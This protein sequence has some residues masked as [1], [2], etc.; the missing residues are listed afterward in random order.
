[1]IRSIDDRFFA[2][3]DRLSLATYVKNVKDEL[4]DDLTR[5]HEDLKSAAYLDPDKEDYHD[6]L[7][8]II[9]R[10]LDLRKNHE[11]V[12]GTINDSTA[13]DVAAETIAELKDKNK[14]RLAEEINAVTPENV[15]SVEVAKMRGTGVEIERRT[16]PP[17][18]EIKP[19]LQNV[20]VIQKVGLDK[21]MKGNPVMLVSTL[22]G[23]QR[24]LS[25][26]VETN[27]QRLLINAG[28]AVEEMLGYTAFTH[29]PTSYLTEESLNGEIAERDI[30]LD[31]KREEYGA[32]GTTSAKKEVLAKEIKQLSDEQMEIR[33][34]LTAVKR[35]LESVTDILVTNV[36][37]S[38]TEHLARI[39]GF[40]PRV[41]VYA[42]KEA[43]VSSMDTVRARKSG[44][45][46]S[47]QEFLRSGGRF[48]HIEDGVTINSMKSELE[49]LKIH[50]VEV[51]R[52]TF[53]TVVENVETG[54][55]IA[56]IPLVDRGKED[57][58]RKLLTGFGELNAIY[59]QSPATTVQLAANGDTK[60]IGYY[61]TKLLADDMGK[62]ISEVY[63]QPDNNIA[64][65]L[66]YVE[67]VGADDNL[68]AGTQASILSK[69]LN[70]GATE[71]VRVGIASPLRGQ[72]NSIFV[73][74]GRNMMVSR[75]M[76]IS[77]A[78]ADRLSNQAANI[79]SKNRIIDVA[80]A[81][82][83][84]DMKAAVEATNVE[85]TA[86]GLMQF[87]E[88]E[89]IED[90][91]LSGLGAQFPGLNID[92]DVPA[93]AY[94]RDQWIADNVRR[95]VKEGKFF[96]DKDGVVR[97]LKPPP[98]QEWDGIKA[99]FKF[100]PMSGTSGMGPEY[101]WR[102]ILMQ[103]KSFGRKI[104]EKEKLINILVDRDNP[105]E[106]QKAFDIL[107]NAQ[108]I[109]VPQGSRG[110]TIS[111]IAARFELVRLYN[112]AIAIRGDAEIAIARG[113]DN[114][115]STYKLVDPERIKNIYSAY[116]HTLLE[117]YDNA[118]I[119][120][121]GEFTP[122]NSKANLDAIKARAEY[123][124]NLMKQFGDRNFAS[125]QVLSR[126]RVNI[127]SNVDILLKTND[128]VSFMD[129]A[130]SRGFAKYDAKA[131]WGELKAATAKIL[132]ENDIRNEL[133]D[134]N[135]RLHDSYYSHN[136]PKKFKKGA[137]P[138]VLVALNTMKYIMRNTLVNDEGRLL[139]RLKGTVELYS[140][141]VDQ[142]QVIVSG[143]RL[144][145]QIQET[146]RNLLK[147]KAL[148]AE[149][150]AHMSA[151]KAFGKE[152]NMYVH[153][154]E[155]VI[156]SL[157]GTNFV[158]F[159]APEVFSDFGTEKAGLVMAVKNDLQGLLSNENLRGAKRVINPKFK[160]IMA[161]IEE[162]DGRVGA[163]K[164]S[165]V[166]MAQGLRGV[167]ETHVN[168][169]MRIFAHEM[170]R[171]KDSPAEY[172]KVFDKAVAFVN[173][174]LG[175][176]PKE[177]QPDII[178]SLPKIDQLRDITK[179]VEPAVRDHV[180][181]A[182]DVV[183]SRFNKIS[184]YAPVV[185]SST[186]TYMVRN[187]VREAFSRELVE[188]ANRRETKLYQLD[189]IMQ[190]LQ[191]I[192]G[193]IWGIQRRAVTPGSGAGTHAA[194]EILSL[195]YDELH[196]DARM[197]Q[198]A[199]AKDSMLEGL[200]DAGKEIESIGY[201]WAKIISTNPVRYAGSIEAV[202]N[203]NK[204]QHVP[205]YLTRDMDILHTDMG[206][207][208]L[209]KARIL[210][211]HNQVQEIMKNIQDGG[212]ITRDSYIKVTDAL[213][214]AVPFDD[215]KLFS[216]LILPKVERYMFVNEPTIRRQQMTAHAQQIYNAFQYR[217]T[218][219]STRID[220]A[221]GAIDRV[222]SY[223]TTTTKFPT[224]SIERERFAH[225]IDRVKVKSF[226]LAINSKSDV[227]RYLLPDG[228]SQGF[229][230]HG[231][232]M[233][234]D[235]VRKYGFGYTKNDTQSAFMFP[236]RDTAKDIAYKVNLS[237][238]M[239][240]DQAEKVLAEAE[241]L[242][243][244]LGVK[245]VVVEVPTSVFTGVGFDK[246]RYPL[247]SERLSRIK[248]DATETPRGIEGAGGQFGVL[249]EDGRSVLRQ[250]PTVIT[251]WD[252][253]SSEVNKGV[254]KA[255]EDMVRPPSVMSDGLIHDVYD[256][257]GVAVSQAGTE[258][259]YAEYVAESAK[260]RREADIEKISKSFA[261]TFRKQG[262][263]LD[264]VMR[265]GDE[266][267]YASR[268][269][270]STSGVT[271]LTT[272][273]VPML[274]Y[275]ENGNIRISR[276]QSDAQTQL[277]L[278]QGAS[279]LPTG[280]QFSIIIDQAADGAYVVKNKAGVLPDYLSNE[281]IYH[282][283]SSVVNAMTNGAQEA[284][285]TQAM[286]EEAGE[287]AALAKILSIPITT[288][289]DTTH[290]LSGAPLTRKEVISTD[291]IKQI[292]RE[293]NA[294]LIAHTAA[295][296]HAS[297]LQ[298]SRREA[299]E[300]VSIKKY[301]ND[302]K[303]LYTR[304]IDQDYK[305]AQLARIKNKYLGVAGVD[306]F[307]VGAP[308][309][310]G[311]IVMANKK[312][313]AGGVTIR[314]EDMPKP[315]FS[316][317][318][319]DAEIEFL[320]SQRVL[321]PED[322]HAIQERIAT[323]R[324]YRPI[325]MSKDREI[326]IMPGAM[327]TFNKMLH[328]NLLQRAVNLSKTI[329]PGDNAEQKLVLERL[330][331]LANEAREGMVDG[332]R[333][334]SMQRFLSGAMRDQA[335]MSG[336][337]PQLIEE[338]NELLN[339]KRLNASQRETLQGLETTIK[340]YNEKMELRGWAV[341]QLGVI[342]SMDVEDYNTVGGYNVVRKVSK[343]AAQEL[344]KPYLEPV[345][346]HIPPAR[347][348][349][350][351][352]MGVNRDY[353]GLF[354][355]LEDLRER[356]R[357]LEDKRSLVMAQRMQRLGGYIKK[358]IE[359]YTNHERYYTDVIN[360]FEKLF[361]DG[362]VKR[363]DDP[364][365]NAGI[366]KQHLRNVQPFRQD[367]IPEVEE[368]FKDAIKVLRKEKD[369][370]AVVE[371]KDLLKNLEGINSKNV[372]LRSDEYHINEAQE[373]ID[374]ARMYLGRLNKARTESESA[375]SVVK[376]QTM[377]EQLS[378]QLV[379][380]YDR[381]GVLDSRVETL[382]N[383]VKSTYGKYAV[384]GL[385]P[386]AK[387]KN[388][389]NELESQQ[390]V[391][392]DPLKS[393]DEVAVANKAIGALEEE[394]ANVKEFMRTHNKDVKVLHKQIEQHEIDFGSRNRLSVPYLTQQA[395][396][397]RIKAHNL[398]VEVEAQ[399]AA[400]VPVSKEHVNLISKYESTS[401]MFQDSMKSKQ[402]LYHQLDALY[403]EEQATRVEMLKLTTIRPEYREIGTWAE[404]YREIAGKLS[405]QGDGIKQ[406][407]NVLA[408]N[409]K[410]WF[411][412]SLF[413]DVEDVHKMLGKAINM[414][415]GNSEPYIH[416]IRQRRIDLGL[417]RAVNK[418]AQNRVAVIMGLMDGYF[419]SQNGLAFGQ[420]PGAEDK[421]IFKGIK[422]R[423]EWDAIIAGIMVPASKT[424]ITTIKLPDGT[425]KQVA[426]GTSNVEMIKALSNFG[427]F[428]VDMLD[429]DMVKEVFGEM[430]R[431]KLGK[432]R[433]TQ[434]ITG[435]LVKIEK[436]FEP[437]RKRLEDPRVAELADVYRGALR[438]SLMRHLQKEEKGI[439][440][441]STVEADTLVDRA[442]DM[443]MGY[444]E[445]FNEM[446]LG[447]A[448]L[449]RILDRSFDKETATRQF[450]AARGQEYELGRQ[451]TA[452]KKEIGDINIEI[453]GSMEPGAKRTVVR[454]LEDRLID[455]VRAATLDMG[456]KD[457]DEII[458]K[459]VL[460]LEHLTKDPELLA[461]REGLNAK[462][463]ELQK[464]HALFN[465]AQEEIKIVTRRK[466][467]LQELISG[468]HSVL[469]I[470]ENS[471]Y[472]VSLIDMKPIAAS[473]EQEGRVLENVDDSMSIFM[474]GETGPNK[475]FNLWRTSNN[476]LY[477]GA[478]NFERRIYDGVLGQI[479]Q[480]T[481]LHTGIS[482]RERA[483]MAESLATVM[484]NKFG[485][486]VDEMY[487]IP[488]V[489]A[490]AG[491]YAK[492]VQVAINK[493]VF[494][495]QL[496]KAM[497]DV[498]IK[499]TG[500]AVDITN[501]VSRFAE[502]K[503]R[504]SEVEPV[505]SDI[506]SG[507]RNTIKEF[508]RGEVHVPY[509]DIQFALSDTDRERA[510]RL[511]AKEL[512]GKLSS[513][514]KDELSTLLSSWGDARPSVIR[515]LVP[516]VTEPEAIYKMML[517]DDGR[518][519]VV[520]DLY[521]F[522]GNEVI[523]GEKVRAP[524]STEWVEQHLNDKVQ[525]M[526]DKQ[527]WGEGTER[528][529]RRK[530]IR[531][532]NDVPGVDKLT[533]D[534]VL[535]SERKLQILKAMPEADADKVASTVLELILTRGMA[536]IKVASGEIQALGL[537]GITTKYEEA[538]K[539]N[540][541]SPKYIRDTINH[542]PTMKTIT[543]I[544]GSYK[545][546]DFNR[547]LDLGEV[548]WHKGQFETFVS[549]RSKIKFEEM[550]SGAYTEE[551]LSKIRTH[552][553]V[554]IGLNFKEIAVFLLA[555]LSDP[556]KVSWG[557]EYK[558]LRGV[559]DVSTS[560]ENK[561]GRL[562]RESEAIKKAA[563]D[564]G[565]GIRHILDPRTNTYI[566]VKIVEF[567]EKTWPPKDMDKW[568]F[569]GK[570]D[571]HFGFK[572]DKSWDFDEYITKTIAELKANRISL[573]LGYDPTTEKMTAWNRR[574]MAMSWVDRFDEKME[575]EISTVIGQREDVL[576]RMAEKRSIEVAEWLAENV[577]AD[578][579]PSTL[580]ADRIRLFVD[581]QHR[582]IA[583]ETDVAV[584][585]GLRA[586]LAL[587][588]G[589]GGLLD[590]VMERGDLN[591]RLNAL[592]DIKDS[593]NVK[594]MKYK[595]GMMDAALSDPDVV[596]VLADR[597]YLLDRHTF[598]EKLR[599]LEV[600]LDKT[601]EELDG[602][603]GRAV[604]MRPVEVVV[605]ASAQVDLVAVQ[606]RLAERISSEEKQVKALARPF[607]L[608][609]NRAHA[610]IDDATLAEFFKTN[611]EYRDTL[612]ELA[613]LINRTE[614]TKVPTSM[615][616]QRLQ[617]LT[618]KLDSIAATHTYA[619]KINSVYVNMGEIYSVDMNIEEVLAGWWGKHRGALPRDLVEKINKEVVTMDAA[620]AE[621]YLAN[622]AMA[623]VNRTA[624]ENGVRALRDM[625]GASI[626][627]IMSH[628]DVVAAQKV[629]DAAEAQVNVSKRRAFDRA[630]AV[631][632]EIDQ[633][634][635]KMTR[636]GKQDTVPVRAVIEA[637]NDTIDRKTFAM[638]N[639]RDRLN[640]ALIELGKDAVDGGFLQKDIAEMMKVFDKPHDYT[641]EAVDVV[642]KGLD[643]WA[644]TR[645]RTLPIVN[646][647]K[648]A[649][650]QSRLSSRA[651]IE[652][653][654]HAVMVLT[655]QSIPEEDKLVKY[656]SKMFGGKFRDHIALAHMPPLLMYPTA[657]E[658]NLK[659]MREFTN[660]YNTTQA[661]LYKNKDSYRKLLGSVVKSGGREYNNAELQA[662]VNR[663]GELE[664]LEW[665]SGVL[666]DERGTYDKVVEYL[667][668]NGWYKETGDIRNRDTILNHAKKDRSSIINKED[669]LTYLKVWHSDN[670]R[671]DAALTGTHPHL[672]KKEKDEL[673]SLR[674]LLKSQ[675]KLSMYRLYMVRD[676]ADIKAMRVAGAANA[677]M[678]DT[679]YSHELKNMQVL[680][681][682][683]MNFQRAY[684]LEVH[685]NM[686]IGLP[687]RVEKELPKMYIA[688]DGTVFMRQGQLV[689]SLARA[690]GVRE[691]TAI[692]DSQTGAISFSKSVGIIG[693]DA[694]IK[695][696]ERMEIVDEI[697]Q[698]I[699]RQLAIT[700]D[701]RVAPEG[702]EF[703][704]TAVEYNLT[705]EERR[706]LAILDD[707]KIQYEVY[708]RGS[709][710]SK[711]EEKEY[712]NLVTKGFP[713]HYEE[714]LKRQEAESYA[715]L[716]F[717]KP[718]GMTEE[719]WFG[720][721]MAFRTSERG[722]YQLWAKGSYMQRLGDLQKEAA[723]KAGVVD[724]RD[725]IFNS[726]HTVDPSMS[727]SEMATYH[728][729]VIGVTA[730]HFVAPEQRETF[731]IA[732]NVYAQYFRDAVKLTGI[733]ENQNALQALWEKSG[734]AAK[735]G[736]KP[737]ATTVRKFEELSPWAGKMIVG[738]MKIGDRLEE[739]FKGLDV[740]LG[741]INGI[742]AVVGRDAQMRSNSALSI[743]IRQAI[744]IGRDAAK[745]QGAASI[746]KASYR[747][748]LNG[749]SYSAKDMVGQQVSM[750]FG[751]HA[752]ATF[753][754][755]KNIFQHTSYYAYAHGSNLTDK[756]M[757][758][759]ADE[760]ANKLP[761]DPQGKQ[762][763]TW[764]NYVTKAGASWSESKY[765]IRS[766]SLVSSLFKSLDKSADDMSRII[767][768][769]VSPQTAAAK[770]YQQVG[771]AFR[772]LKQG[773][774]NLVGDAGYDGANTTLS[775][776]YADNV[777]FIS[778]LEY[779]AVNDSRTCK[780][781]RASDGMLYNVDDPKPSLPRHGNC[782]CTYRAWFRQ[783]NEMLP[784]VDV[785]EESRPVRLKR[786]INIGDDDL[787]GLG[788]G[789]NKLKPIKPSG[790][791]ADEDWLRWFDE[792]K[793][794]VREMMVGKDHTL[795]HAL[796]AFDDEDKF[797][798]SRV[799][800]ATARDVIAAAYSDT[801]KYAGI[802]LAKK[803]V[804][805]HEVWPNLILAVADRKNAG[806]HL[807]LIPFKRLLSEPGGIVQD[808]LVGG[809]NKMMG[810]V[811]GPGGALFSLVN[812][813]VPHAMMKSA[814]EVGSQM[815]KDINANLP[816]YIADR[817][818]SV[819]KVKLSDAVGAAVNK[820][821]PYSKLGAAYAH[822]MSIGDVQGKNIHEKVVGNWFGS[823]DSLVD[824][825]T[826]TMFEIYSPMGNN[827]AK[828]EGLAAKI[829]EQ[830][831]AMPMDEMQAALSRR[832]KSSG[833]LGE[834]PLREVPW[835][836]PEAYENA[837]SVLGNAYTK[838][839]GIEILD[840]KFLSE[841]KGW[842]TSGKVWESPELKRRILELTP[843]QQAQIRINVGFANQGQFDLLVQGGKIDTA[844]S[845]FRVKRISPEGDIYAFNDLPVYGAK[846]MWGGPDGH[847]YVGALD[848]IVDT[849][850]V[851]DTTVDI[852]QFKKVLVKYGPSEGGKRNISMMLEKDSQVRGAQN[853]VEL[854]Q[855]EGY[856]Q[857]GLER[858]MV[859]VEKRAYT[860]FP[861]PSTRPGL[862]T[863]EQQAK[864]VAG[865]KKLTTNTVALT[866]LGSEGKFINVAI[867][868]G[869][870]SG[871]E[872]VERNFNAQIMRAI[873]VVQKEDMLTGKSLNIGDRHR[874]W[875]LAK[876][877]IDQMEPSDIQKGV[878]NQLNNKFTSLRRIQELI[879]WASGIN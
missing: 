580:S 132:A 679:Q 443:M 173:G 731:T 64:R 229:G 502:E 519:A 185:T 791:M 337:M 53:G 453:Y 340:T 537:G 76:A 413:M 272:P 6:T 364:V 608:A 783:P 237:Y 429:D 389:T 213:V 723:T 118:V 29:S 48:K 175:M 161:K 346:E 343:T 633:W 846:E 875:D 565:N 426:G 492:A 711:G 591:A 228:W 552:N 200:V 626:A 798:K 261:R 123:T 509:M 348:V 472:D 422:H 868:S 728:D 460:N 637:F 150:D 396:A 766:G 75:K 512:R 481:G 282:K 330:L 293:E 184:Q 562:E 749:I 675:L 395:E 524:L 42:N 707:K 382:P 78:T 468:K 260:V 40:N 400:N 599:T 352:I 653:L 523:K 365:K 861:P 350:D 803:F 602:E 312:L 97:I 852:A 525:R 349:V 37:N 872:L 250:F 313:G 256:F 658:E 770:G 461:L 557:T 147:A 414:A 806:A 111:N 680:N 824:A 518:M 233:H 625:Q 156:R 734:V 437:A 193:R 490:G 51:G 575:S 681:G 222:V 244:K 466:T 549:L 812:K 501:I 452:L 862:L 527:Y 698:D 391:L 725:L 629:V 733:I 799:V 764:M 165:E 162:I 622:L 225:D 280:A 102:R 727:V 719:E 438:K 558:R 516:G 49:G 264:T 513:K 741:N 603:N 320:S 594:E 357:A 356:A 498:N 351:M 197:A 550:V 342:G 289:W 166:S 793:Y 103:D 589:K 39:Q 152:F 322:T 294:I 816:K 128:E 120:T 632:S 678:S 850:R 139:A 131:L 54:G 837:V 2:E 377:A 781:C 273:R 155:N 676:F 842:F 744:S 673:D 373:G 739:L 104:G 703:K 358:D 860:S 149:I 672:S 370:A 186:N 285:I 843:E 593:T 91:R 715:R 347:D 531:V 459:V 135:K 403:A 5:M 67:M 420:H 470:A 447:R 489:E 596:Q 7:R 33:K 101:D 43:V 579:I 344:L 433:L 760:I 444:Q 385:R 35:G 217:V 455:G 214:K 853:M 636:E 392:V 274:L 730:E 597:P 815:W 86:L 77:N 404:K 336:H 191:R 107:F 153:E 192:P 847:L 779:V 354:E 85:K 747:H 805:N 302:V 474:P 693:T 650:F 671:L 100:N 434:D 720:R 535:Q 510:R 81:D 755:L 369:I 789:L 704:R 780:Y 458:N 266:I 329:T 740:M 16:V 24:G 408:S 399:M 331:H 574:L 47:V 301:E 112:D 839:G 297:T 4:L 307:G 431:R 432:P 605:P 253:K 265:R 380:A 817:L 756:N 93:D 386:Q 196:N 416:E 57:A 345:A 300:N 88:I 204:L 63:A 71:K 536:K 871:Y 194:E 108:Y 99:R 190:A 584:I 62:L 716:L 695:T 23:D 144:F 202:S 211:L 164:G 742:G 450:I 27:G 333:V 530:I 866:L 44:I 646:E 836:S 182:V 807:K 127:G 84:A 534:E 656:A 363:T 621:G 18:P 319:I 232:A 248:L 497:R 105:T 90:K 782:R 743:F 246:A 394:Q 326:T 674:A 528:A 735:V 666:R 854:R 623:N 705:N 309:F 587:V 45:M 179:G 117:E 73:R 449:A 145:Y 505:I 463:A 769:G 419:A 80:A 121:V 668:Q 332:Q 813:Y 89:D 561:I 748:A 119:S 456:I 231:P 708:L 645:V 600:T 306:M 804:R 818:T 224:V 721:K 359:T 624:A 787:G 765:G 142:L 763:S 784:G 26:L 595:K 321:Y 494:M 635:L 869:K 263:A 227:D 34:K 521:A 571:R 109:D 457:D 751:G 628:P 324:A 376:L 478:S 724:M 581:A 814:L 56:Y 187:D 712:R 412:K 546:E 778:K 314:F 563:E 68:F 92:E 41:N 710:L 17:L 257:M 205:G 25:V 20:E 482:A 700:K 801:V 825:L 14:G 857:Q 262:E 548:V 137:K 583:Y 713:K 65:S 362:P 451:I 879:A 278:K 620:Q 615:Y 236:I 442:L 572:L 188:L 381:I 485:V 295:M 379:L 221:R 368:V 738:G 334:A 686:R 834:L 495:S 726:V 662:L 270:K 822:M 682:H 874:V 567:T 559:A 851:Y 141:A 66:Q 696:P 288:K 328:K 522:S 808:S 310:D 515:G 683:L 198:L 529:F 465:A 786:W 79:R 811:A 576:G 473:L 539:A 19:K 729:L 761:W 390:K 304:L 612:S 440:D 239:G 169:E 638:K 532:Y 684:D 409:D 810:D 767:A 15:D 488:G 876:Q 50:L 133:E 249:M 30:V 353:I 616:A 794:P 439:S 418:M 311:S 752:L 573:N 60:Y 291:E 87:A 640:T 292:Q 754:G 792:Q 833:V 771:A 699:D 560:L 643:E 247:L 619:S 397:Y 355:E 542:T 308:D 830:L 154:Y 398:R 387:L 303:A 318:L 757:R 526:S 316:S 243:L 82:A 138:K 12:E 647:I 371:L 564:T 491:M 541:I 183:V 578:I 644:S 520:R 795:A 406:I 663:V 110:E 299:A 714:L 831:S 430:G 96:K 32:R 160:E 216:E 687:G 642:V 11:D 52:G 125:K 335:F 641:D 838:K 496:V 592:K 201:Q 445:S 648:E 835:M 667:G 36:D 508:M 554:P 855:V 652:T 507:V 722:V 367:Q 178:A 428:Y 718:V 665:G 206:A 832:V 134:M 148:R 275:V 305:F 446:A 277:I 234:M 753:T 819:E 476:N 287:R 296:E 240:M 840:S 630:S 374:Q 388:I 258:S 3:R 267:F 405:M 143:K 614:L 483:D 61:G 402:L 706:L 618:A 174:R 158:L 126:A 484:R 759:L 454:G 220:N 281:I 410:L 487:R 98:G 566:P 384:L 590:L 691:V 685:G 268:E 627:E 692:Q 775:Y 774:E 464:V 654:Q 255:H 777:Q 323:L 31:A 427:D 276:L 157:Q 22:S 865:Q 864:R 585:D 170:D 717:K 877:Y 69:M 129:S 514:E 425:F 823:M 95:G 544:L 417:M 338:R 223:V 828:V 709:G 441:L 251:S 694:S 659:M 383:I 339:M 176:T 94:R 486:T 657:G 411:V 167:L 290:E 70:E 180:V 856:L 649:L 271:H 651:Y 607:R 569:G 136:V 669:I 241:V 788:A 873:E 545:V 568:A 163:I 772:N 538:L 315:E 736:L 848:D 826:N 570:E 858:M 750:M 800:A 517:L 122:Y 762:I 72:T 471:W 195:A 210:E 106:A 378:S 867:G 802:E 503:F 269:A 611:T 768:Q 21:L 773:E 423:K 606:V 254:L 462:Y 189:K 845:R 171:V 870:Y 737:V 533:Y 9:R 13:G 393:S 415:R 617:E 790:T 479:F 785:T 235:L 10:E 732:A 327:P 46:E 283:I 436:M 298:P 511:V 424:T 286:I 849:M 114:I 689:D 499:A 207:A 758:M 28:G 360:T 212:T 317:E 1:M 797:D 841:A 209:E 181:R 259:Q 245:K 151:G 124:K 586:Q 601:R 796:G 634:I 58:V 252:I 361:W 543:A 435:G 506:K 588:E 74:V 477:V 859:D 688:Q 238:N 577:S 540:G 375:E 551:V 631:F 500:V 697:L 372:I 493:E 670:R 8:Y 660:D 115:A 820:D 480:E 199:R 177:T 230:D 159:D 746:L 146:D 421:Y 661:S 401:K 172:K 677:Y 878:K 844:I 475:L 215:R 218:E 219:L 609:L 701:K 130:A 242:A 38:T 407:E 341:R 168:T 226:M 366:L 284:T 745:L 655:D 613:A 547:I 83:E 827:P 555:K 809:V 863:T 113:M 690:I 55:R 116:V 556:K 702:M 467:G 582:A 598:D 604:L 821:T 140:N 504:G 776:A 469:S 59:M 829:Q 203:L 448:K 664:E 553:A 325:S 279:I 610:I 208:I 639:T